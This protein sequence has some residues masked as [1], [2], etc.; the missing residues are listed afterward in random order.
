[1]T[2]YNIDNYDDSVLPGTFSKDLREL[3]DIAVS[4]GWKVITSS[5]QVVTLRSYDDVKSTRIGVS[6]SKNLDLNR[7]RRGIMKHADPQYLDAAREA[8]KHG[9]AKTPLGKVP[10][11]AVVPKE[12]VE[13]LEHMK[14][15]LE[16]AQKDEPEAPSVKPDD[17]VRADAH[18]ISEK[19]MIAKSSDGEGYESPTTIERRWSDGSRDYKCV[20]C[21][22]TSPDRLAPSR[23][24]SGAHARGQGRKQAPPRFKVDVPDAVTYN[25]NAKRVIALAT[26]IEQM[27][28][29]GVTD[30][31]VIAERALTW[32]HE[33]HGTHVEDPE[34]LDD[35]AIL[36][37]I[38]SLLDD[39]SMRDTQRRIEALEEQVIESQRQVETAIE[40]A[41]VWKARAQ[42]ARDTLRAFTE[43]AAEASVE[44]SA[45]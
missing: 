23:H 18:I 28:K 25:P 30:P 29:D 39:G 14:E 36:A 44:E 6:N 20:D 3:I 7:M 10:L 37:R 22:F 42:R 35:S 11:S 43:L 17:H 4:L 15:E 1:M 45:G 31:K 33:Q 5:R 24:Y 38:R 8:L 12:V 41:D 32:V 13:G 9:T 26:V 16:E 2:T 40:Q 34:P 19:P 27:M 21:D